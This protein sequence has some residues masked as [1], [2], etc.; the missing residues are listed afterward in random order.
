MKSLERGPEIVVYG[1]VCFVQNLNTA[2]V[3]SGCFFRRDYV[4]NID[5]VAQFAIVDNVLRVAAGQPAEI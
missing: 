2:I 5:T 3:F 1:I 4:S